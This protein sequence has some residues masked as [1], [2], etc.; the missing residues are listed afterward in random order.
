[1]LTKLEVLALRRPRPTPKKTR[2]ATERMT[3]DELSELAKSATYIGSSHHKDV[4]AMN[5]VPTPRRGAMHIA[6]AEAQ[7]L[8]KPD[9]MICPRKWAGR[10]SAATELLRVGICSGQVS[11][12]AAADSL[13][14]RVWVR[15]PDDTNIVYEA[16]RLSHPENGYKAYPLTVRQSRNL[17]LVV[18]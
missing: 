9:C 12:D 16:K 13:P 5:L 3:A 1:M 11:F 8:D 14:T 6:E 2:P 10:Q 7:D 15:D 4:P 17:P 18:K